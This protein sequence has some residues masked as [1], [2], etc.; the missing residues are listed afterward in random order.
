MNYYELLKVPPTAS[1]EEIKKA[2]LLLSK[3]M[4]PD[5]FDVKTQRDQWEKANEILKDLIDKS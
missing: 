4:H 3:M 1:F 2:Y 5:K